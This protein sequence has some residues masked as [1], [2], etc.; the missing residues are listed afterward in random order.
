M[1]RLHHLGKP[2]A[3]PH[4]SHMEKTD[5]TEVEKRQAAQ[6][7]ALKEAEERR[8]ALTSGPRPKNRAGKKA[9]S[10]RAMA[11]GKKPALSLIF[12]CLGF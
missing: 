9:P 5:K 8:A 10:R 4:I 11:I 7:A 6:Q 3:S 12:D 1:S 2:P